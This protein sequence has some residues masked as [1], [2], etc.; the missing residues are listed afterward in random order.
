[1]LNPDNKKFNELTGRLKRK[2]TPPSNKGY[3]KSKE[4]NSLS[5]IKP[6]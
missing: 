1:M 2:I 3:S 4:R 6:R 5:F